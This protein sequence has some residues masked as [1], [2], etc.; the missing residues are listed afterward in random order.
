MAKTNIWMALYPKDWLG[1]TQDLTT[2]QHGAY[3]LLSI[4]YFIQGGPPRDS[5]DELARIAKLS[6]RAWLR[7]RERISRFFDIRDGFWFHK[8][9]ERE[10]ARASELSDRAR[11][12]AEKRWEG[13]REAVKQELPKAINDAAAHATASEGQMPGHML[14]TCYSQSQSQSPTEAE[15]EQRAEPQARVGAERPSLREVSDYAQFIGLAPWKAE[16]WFDEMQGGG[17]LDHNRRPVDD[18]RAVMRRVRKKWE[19]DGRPMGPPASTPRQG[20]GAQRPMSPLDLKTII[21]AKEGTANA[22]KAKFASETAMGLSWNDQAKRTEWVTIRRE[23][24]ALNQ[25]LSQMA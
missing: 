12:K 25:K 23:I 2:Q 5:D 6:R 3:F 7:E 14:G 9:I 4:A 18:W 20:G 19:A 1:D 15:R 16:D 13:K 22:I 11:Q 17:W 10:L 24:K 21:Q 8:R